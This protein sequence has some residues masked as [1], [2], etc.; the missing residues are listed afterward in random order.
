[1]K[2][3]VLLMMFLSLVGVTL[4]AQSKPVVVVAS[5]NAKG[6][7][8]DEAEVVTELFTSE[9]ANTG[10]VDVVDRNNFDKISDQLKFQS[11]DWS[12]A[13]KVAQ[14]GKALNAN[15]VVVGQLLRFRE[16]VAVTIKV[17]DV[18][19]TTILASHTGKLD[20]MEDLLDELPKICKE[21]SEK[22]GGILGKKHEKEESSEIDFSM[23]EKPCY[24]HW[25]AAEPK[26]HRCLSDEKIA[27]AL[28]EAD[29]KYK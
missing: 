3:Y 19:T 18:N 24:L 6:V 10:M 13:D 20:D 2:K 26:Q 17:I 25:P 14:L 5:F 23:T 15:H 27:D 22:T 28:R 8:K 7:D 21:L 12:N 16:K 1:M 4:F 9:Y 29:E 11:S